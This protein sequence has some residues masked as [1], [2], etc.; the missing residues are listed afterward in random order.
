[1]WILNMS[2]NVSLNMALIFSKNLSK[3]IRVLGY[4]RE[5]EI[6]SIYEFYLWFL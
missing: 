1:M 6:Y 3:F 2:L 5:L 4:L